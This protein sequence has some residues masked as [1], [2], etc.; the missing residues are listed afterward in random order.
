MTGV[1]GRAYISL[2]DKMIVR[3]P[4]LK[5]GAAV[6]PNT[7]MVGPFSDAFF[8]DRA[9]VCEKLSEILL[10]SDSFTVI[11]TAKASCNG[12]LAFTLLYAHYLGLNNVNYM[13]R[14]AEKV[15][16]SSTYHGEKRN[17]T[18]EKDALLHLKQHH[19]LEGLNPHGY[20]GIDPEPKVH[21]LNSGIK[22]NTLEAVKSRIILDEHLRAD[23]ARCV[24]HYKDVVKQTVNTA[25]VQMGIA[26][27][28]VAGTDK[29]EDHWYTH[30]E[31]KD[32]PEDEQAAI[33]KACAHCKSKKGGDRHPIK[34]KPTTGKCRRKQFQQLEKRVQNQ[35]RQLA[36]LQAKSASKSDEAEPMKEGDSDFDGNI[37]KHSALM[38]QPSDTRKGCKGKDSKS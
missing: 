17:W 31:L 28:N 15:L 6:G 2:D 5:M 12:R 25:N 38:R 29:G 37:C 9:T 24:T 27:L 4:I 20:T 7:E 22:T 26:A 1:V 3:G 36:A 8:V 16:A 18:F 23:I 11:K 10:T 13:A 21:H 19:I 34:R 14:E 30:E 33:R 32:F 35:K